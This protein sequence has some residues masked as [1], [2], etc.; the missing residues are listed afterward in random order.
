MVGAGVVD[1]HLLEP[2]DLV[3]Q[4]LGPP[5]Q[6]VEPTKVALEFSKATSVP[7][8]RQTATLGSSTAE[9]P[10]VVVFQN[11]VVTSLS[12]TLAGLA[13]TPCRL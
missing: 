1:V 6:K 13:A 12:P 5:E 9:K 4:R 8:R 3:R 7:E 2:C 11:C 10:R